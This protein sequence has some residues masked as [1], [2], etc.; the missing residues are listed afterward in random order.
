MFAQEPIL[1]PAGSG[2]W[3]ARSYWQGG[4]ASGPRAAGCLGVAGAFDSGGAGLWWTVDGSR[5]GS[6]TQLLSRRQR[7]G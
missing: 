3:A 1:M 7:A 5:S 2:P 6:G 4:P